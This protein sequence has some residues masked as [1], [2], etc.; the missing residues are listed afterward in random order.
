MRWEQLGAQSSQWTTGLGNRG[1]AL[2]LI[3][4]T[5]FHFLL[6]FH[7]PLAEDELYYWS[8]ARHLQWSYFDHPPMVAYLIRV[9]T[10]IFGQNAFGIRFFAS[11]AS[12]LVLGLLAL[13]MRS[14]G[15]LLAVAFS[16]IVLVLSIY[17]TPDVPLMVFWLLYALWGVSVNRRLQEW[18]ADPM[19]R[20]YHQSPIPSALWALGGVCLG[21]G[22]LSKYTMAL[23]PVCFGLLCLFNYRPRAWLKGF[24]LHAGIA[25]LVAVPILIYNIQNGFLPV[26]FQ[27]NHSLGA[28]APAAF[29]NYLSAQVLL[30]GALPFVVLPWILGF[31]KRLSALPDLQVFLYFFLVPLSL[32][33]IQATR[34]P[35]EGNWGI[36][37]YVTFW[38]VAQTLFE[39]NSFKTAARVFIALCMAPAFV[40]SGALL[41]HSM[42]PIGALPVE[43][44]RYSALNGKFDA[45]KH[46][47]AALAEKVPG[48]PVFAFTYQWQSYLNYFGVSSRPTGGGRMHHFRM[49]DPVQVCE[50]NNVLALVENGF[51]DP[52]LACFGQ[53]ELVTEVP[54]TVREKA[55]GR[56]AVFRFSKGAA[57][58]RP[59]P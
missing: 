49:R 14:R 39:D 16:P 4:F 42:H 29:W 54:V 21:L 18:S 11:L 20:V 52:S 25:A 36:V 37:A 34:A 40:V 47:A 19:R 24:A 30:V 28:T 43:K 55:A 3:A 17:M 6:S 27:W 32:F 53:R 15:L 7:F 31:R 57:P 12:T 59:S 48:E 10:A 23:A 56:L 58:S 46:L 13:Q 33:L 38:P 50:Q 8:W 5:L 35:M 9:S 26:K 41:I 2:G 1:L 22:L 44:D 45:T 51:T